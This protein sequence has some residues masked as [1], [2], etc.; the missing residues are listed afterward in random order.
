MLPGGDH[1]CGSWVWPA[2]AC[3][4]TGIAGPVSKGAGQWNR[5]SWSVMV[6]ARLRD[7]SLKRLLRMMVFQ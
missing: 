5:G 6:A 7:G 3:A 2:C 4:E 1:G